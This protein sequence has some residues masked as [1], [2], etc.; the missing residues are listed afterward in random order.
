MHPI[1]AIVLLIGF[2]VAA[3]YMRVDVYSY[4]W[5]RVSDWWDVALLV[6]VTCFYS[7]IVAGL[8]VG[9]IA[10]PASLVVALATRLRVDG[11]GAETRLGHQCQF[12]GYDLRGTSGV[13]CPERGKPIYGRGGGHTG[14]ER[15][16]H[17][18]R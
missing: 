6:L 7:G 12:C 18:P 14:P 4:P 3:I 2:T 13:T 15:R 16:S 5:S 1:Y 17:A 9:A 11:L 8:L 10:I